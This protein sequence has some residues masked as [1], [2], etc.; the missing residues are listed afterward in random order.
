MSL[1]FALFDVTLSFFANHS[2]S[3]AC[4]MVLL[5]VTFVLH[6]FLHCRVG[7]DLRYTRYGVGARLV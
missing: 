4:I 6:S 1:I 2:N 5:K 7:D 3:S